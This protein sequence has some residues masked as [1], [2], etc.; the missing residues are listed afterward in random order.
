MSCQ[1]C[2]L[3]GERGKGR[4]DWEGVCDGRPGRVGQ[5][6]G[7]GDGELWRRREGGREGGVGG[8][9]RKRRGVNINCRCEL[10]QRILLSIHGHST[11]VVPARQCCRA[12][13]IPAY[14]PLFPLSPSLPP[15]LPPSLQSSYSPATGSHRH[16][17]L[18]RRPG[19]SSR[20]GRRTPHRQRTW[21]FLACGQPREG[22]R[23]GGRMGERSLLVAGKLTHQK[24]NQRLS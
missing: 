22:G 15:S 9:R 2:R 8:S 19:W 18:A 6:V 3:G 23:E 17:T 13:F 7:L 1:F 14:A 24:G 12:S 21:C 11:I 5:V 10:L 4:E 16:C 20:R